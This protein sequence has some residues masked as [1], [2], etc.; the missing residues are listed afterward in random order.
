MRAILDL[1]LS[2]PLN[3]DSQLPAQLITLTLPRGTQT[4]R[5]L[6][7]TGALRERVT[8]LH[9]PQAVGMVAQRSAGIC[10]AV[11]LPTHLARG[12]FPKAGE[13]F[14][15][16]HGKAVRNVQA[17]KAAAWPT[18]RFRASRRFQTVAPPM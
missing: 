11:E 16:G 6:L 7:Q 12:G 10:E 5:N 4:G 18:W 9:R 3:A 17:A 1:D 14:E 8:V 13:F 2:I 15:P